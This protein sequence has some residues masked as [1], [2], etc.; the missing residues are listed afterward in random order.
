MYLC[1]I[2]KK[3]TFK[4]ID[5][6][7]DFSFK[8]LFIMKKLLFYSIITMFLFSC[9]QSFNGIS[10]GELPAGYQISG[11]VNSYDLVYGGSGKSDDEYVSGMIVDNSGSMYV[12][13]NVTTDR[14][15]ENLIITKVKS[16]GTLAWGQQYDATNEK[17]PDSGENGE[18]GG[19]AGSISID[20]EGNIYIISTETIPKTSDV[21]LIIK[22]NASTG[23]IMWQKRWKLE[24]PADG[25]YGLAYQSSFG[26]AIDATGD[27]VYFT[28]STGSNKVVVNALNKEDGSLFFQYGLDIVAGSMS[29]GYAIKN[30][31]NGNLFIG[32]VNGSYSFFAKIGNANT[33]SPTLTWVK[34]T[35]LPFGARINGI[36]IDNSGVYFS[37]DIRGVDTYFEIMKIDF[38]GNL[39]WAKS[40]PGASGN[41]NNTHSISI[42]G[43]YVYAGGSIRITGMDELG[44]AIVVKL[45]KENGNLDW[46]GIYTTGNLS[47]ESSNQRIKGIA[48][49]NDQIFV[50][51]QIYPANANSE[52]YYG[53]WV[54]SNLNMSD[55]SV[56]FSNITED[57]FEPFTLGEVRD[58]EGIMSQYTVATLQNSKNKI[59]QNT[60][61]CDAFMMK[62]SLTEQ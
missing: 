6:I 34:D 36:D 18:T 29:R 50:A 49:L 45:S 42:F 55:F 30:D 20:S 3:I 15:N 4:I 44:D 51:G 32:G 43:D 56:N 23:E 48:F 24:W 25:G 14:A 57:A 37:C 7:Q 12:S 16:D 33:Q 41:K 10:N 2:L 62:F 17:T 21:I 47:E 39:K 19:T 22:I 54:E 59:A 5:K 1:K 35:G 9:N 27:Y 60:P 53:S 40:F 28:G 8:K 58:G 46:F 38:D 11:V 61:D 52:H 13:M 26:Y 31:G